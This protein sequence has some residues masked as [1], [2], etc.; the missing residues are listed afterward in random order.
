LQVPQLVRAVLEGFPLSASFRGRVADSS[1]SARAAAYGLYGRWIER[2]I[3][4]LL[5]A[6]GLRLITERL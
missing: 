1:A 6:F 3:G 5:A 4:T 2:A